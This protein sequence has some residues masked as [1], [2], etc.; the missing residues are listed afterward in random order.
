MDLH[1]HLENGASEW[2]YNQLDS[3]PASLCI[4][5]SVRVSEPRKAEQSSITVL[6]ELFRYT[7][8]MTICLD[9]NAVCVFIKLKQQKDI[10]RTPGSRWL[11]VRARW[12]SLGTFCVTR[13]NTFHYQVFVKEN[14]SG[15]VWQMSLNPP[16][17]GFTAWLYVCN[18]MASILY[19]YSQ[20]FSFSVSYT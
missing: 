13:F 1:M 9:W 4:C 19:F 7:A 14:E 2:N 16:H 5:V 3:L 12:G 20:L 6:G 11:C 15:S 17:P 18:P 8:N 10:V